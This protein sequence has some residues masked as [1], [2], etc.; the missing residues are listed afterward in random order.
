MNDCTFSRL[1][2]RFVLGWIAS[3]GAIAQAQTPPADAIKETPPVAKVSYAKAVEPL[4]RDKCQGCHQP[5][6]PQGKYEM[7]S[8]AR[9]VAGGESG[10]AAVVPGKPDESYLVEQ[11]SVHDGK[12]QMPK[13]GEPLSASE[14]ALI[15]QWISEGAVDDR[16][17]NAGPLYSPERPPRYDQ[18]P[19]VT[20]IN[21][22]PNGKWLAVSGF[23]EVLLIAASNWQ[24]S[25]RLIGLSER[26]ESVAFSAD[27]TRLAVTGGSPGRMGEVQVW[28]VENAKLLLSHQ[29]TFD[30]IY[31]GAFSPDGKL[32]AFGCSDNTVRA[33][34]AE[35]GEQKLF[36]GAHEDWVRACVF[37]PDGTHLISGGRDMAVKLV[38]V[39]TERFVDN[40]TSI[41]PGALRGGINSLAR[42]PSRNEIL[43]GGSDGIPKVYRV[44]RVTDRRIGDDSNLVR[45]FPAQPGRIFSV[46]TSADGGLLAAASTLD[47]NSALRVYKYNFDGTLPDNVKAVMAKTSGERNADERKLL[48]EYLAKDITQVAAV[49]LPKASIYTIAF[50]PSAPLIAAG[51]SDGRIRVINVTTVLP[52]SPLHPRQQSMQ[53][54]S[55]S[56]TRLPLPTRMVWRSSPR[57]IQ[58]S[59]K[60]ACPS[61]SWPNWKSNRPQSLWQRIATMRNCWSRP[62]TK[63]AS[64]A[65]SRVWRS[66]APMQMRSQSRQV[67]SCGRRLL[68][69]R[70]STSSSQG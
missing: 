52:K 39:A 60:I 16:A 18:P 19:V 69:K 57:S 43:V 41:T 49:D 24:L 10:A 3:I 54:D 62:F 63:M 38:E 44:F 45:Q 58:K 59:N 50:H 46:A 31:G 15:R 48:D 13:K 70:T 55:K 33:I 21:F 42:H 20:S 27:S 22:S 36:S 7:T 23:H 47:G 1:A 12:A 35:T 9:L 2:S 25:K 53:Q 65:T 30:T 40:I 4:L 51:S 56:A 26:I 8:F 6:K 68:R 32:I 29:I 5:A 64:V 37:T 67:D 14:I 11:I 17:A 61:Q 34:D 28:D 66:T